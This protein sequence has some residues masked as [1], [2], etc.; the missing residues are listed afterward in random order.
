M[1]GVIRISSH[2]CKKEDEKREGVILLWVFFL[3]FFLVYYKW[4][5]SGPD[6]IACK[7]CPGCQNMSLNEKM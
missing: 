2:V 4:L 7:R 3:F 1:R 6:E 5:G